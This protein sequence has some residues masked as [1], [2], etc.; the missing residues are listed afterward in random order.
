MKT[1]EIDL[2]SLFVNGG[3][4]CLFRTPVFGENGPLNQGT[5]KVNEALVC[6][7]MG[8]KGGVRTCAPAGCPLRKYKGGIRV[9]LHIPQ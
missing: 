9:K 6:P 2:E 3:H 4:S 5:C 8:P 1:Y 7:A